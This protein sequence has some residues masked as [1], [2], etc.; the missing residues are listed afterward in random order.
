MLLMS[1]VRR[2]LIILIMSTCA[3]LAYSDVMV[4]QVPPYLTN[5]Y[6]RVSA[7]AI[8]GPFD[9]AEIYVNGEFVRDWNWEG[10][11]MQHMTI[12]IVL[13]ST[14]FTPNHLVSVEAEF[15]NTNG[16]WIVDSESGYVLNDGFAWE[17]KEFVTVSG[18][19]SSQLVKAEMEAAGWVAGEDHSNAW[20]ANEV[21]AVL[22]GCG[23]HYVNSHGGNDQ[24]LV[25]N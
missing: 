16:T 18:G 2:V 7:T 15:R 11:A 24:P 5:T 3:G 13:D 20:S 9:K 10:G 17:Y 22:E 8:G 25:I 21:D 6:N 12:S 19:H 14:H 23:L 1:L 4:M